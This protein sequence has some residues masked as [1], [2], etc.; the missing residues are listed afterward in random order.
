MESTLEH[1]ENLVA[2]VGDLAET[3]VDMW[4]LQGVSKVSEAC[5]SMLSFLAIA[6]FGVIALSII[7]IGLAYVIGN[8]LNNTGYGFFTVG[9]FY[10][11][12]GLIL[13]FC[14]KKWLK[15]P[16]QNLII[17]KLML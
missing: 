9:A 10:A 15:Q 1:I 14:R 6:I 7:N 8:A 13:F 11:L 4:K 2:K 12:V 16:L 3:K 5:S 17:T